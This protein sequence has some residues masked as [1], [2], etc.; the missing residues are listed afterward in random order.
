MYSLTSLGFGPYFQEQPCVDGAI[1][2]RIA[3]EYKHGYLVWFEYDEGFAR[4]SGRLMRDLSEEARPTVRPN[5]DHRTG[6][7]EAQ[8]VH[9]RRGRS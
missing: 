6:T 8:R 4:L 2:A 5:R 3:G 1:P 7:G 9:A